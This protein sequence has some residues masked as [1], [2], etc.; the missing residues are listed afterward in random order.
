MKFEK[1]GTLTALWGDQTI[2]I[3]LFKRNYLSCKF[4]K[5]H[6]RTN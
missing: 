2:I 1:V 4:K 5:L 6:S 3:D